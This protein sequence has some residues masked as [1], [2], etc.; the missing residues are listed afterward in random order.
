MEG[1]INMK[2]LHVN[3]NYMHNKL[4]QTMLEHFE[5][6]NIEHSVFCPISNKSKITIFLFFRLAF[7]ASEQLLLYQT[8]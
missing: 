3:C 8:L 2:I 6:E 5:D 1:K 4:H 7:L